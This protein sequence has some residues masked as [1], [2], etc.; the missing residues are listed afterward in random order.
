MKRT[1][2][3]VKNLPGGSDEVGGW[4]GGLRETVMSKEEVE[5]L[6]EGT[7]EV[8][9]LEG[10]FGEVGSSIRPRTSHKKGGRLKVNTMNNCR[11]VLSAPSHALLSG[12]CKYQ[13]ILLC[14]QR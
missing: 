8:G 2:V 5:I 3:E 13:F 14:S 4:L 1:I 6:A 7:G 9:R 11:P 10:G 12:Y